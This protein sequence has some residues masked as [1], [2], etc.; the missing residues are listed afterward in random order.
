MATKDQTKADKELAQTYEELLRLR[1]RI[2]ELRT[3]MPAEEVKNYALKTGD[4]EAVKLYDLFGD[5]NDLIL[6]HNMGKSC[7]YCVLW[8]DGFN[9]VYQ[10]LENRAGFALVSPDA[11]DVV[12]AFAD[13]RGWKFRTLSNDGGEFTG[14]MGYQD[15]K[16]NPHPGISTFHRDSDGKVTRVAHSPFGPGDDFC[17][18]WHM[19]DMLKDGTNKWAPKYEY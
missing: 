11:P 3:S 4:G 10:H 5:K 8:A 1:K 17:A 19:F 14:D 6:I 13:S 16:G 2:A 7:P 18:V 15:D 12:K 9:G